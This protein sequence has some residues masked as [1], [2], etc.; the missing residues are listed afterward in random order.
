MKNNCIICNN[1]F[2]VSNYNKHRKFCSKLC[3][4]KYKRI[5]YKNKRK[6]VFCIICNK[7]IEVS[8]NSH[9]KFCSHPCYWKYKKIYKIGGKPR[10]RK[11]VDCK[12]CKKPFEVI[13]SSKRIYCSRRCGFD[14]KH[15]I[16]EFF[17]TY[18]KKEMIVSISSNR[19]FCSI[20]CAGKNRKG[21]KLS[22]E[23][24]EKLVK[25]HLGQ[26]SNKKDRKFEEIYG[27][28]R[29]KEIKNKISK[30]VKLRD[31][32]PVGVFKKG[33]IP[34]NK[35]RKWEEMFGYEEAIKRKKEWRFYM[36]NNTV[37][38]KKDSKPEL[39]MQNIL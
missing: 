9:R 1:E 25:G 11:I 2:N 36:I 12:Y 27:P 28:I 22:K 16:K 5:Y 39:L 33:N 35:N 19:K 3:F 31:F 14:E 24:I 23:Y 20:I 10:N 15:K 38:P 17:C 8:K 26:K 13:K 37:V 30:K 34:W 21:K 32:I 6:K 29:A 18:C 4:G 7:K